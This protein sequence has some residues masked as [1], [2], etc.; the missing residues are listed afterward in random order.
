MYS[1][2]FRRLSMM[3]V[4]LFAIIT[5]TFFLMHAVPGGPFVSE[6]ML[7]PEIAAALNAKYGLDLPIWQQYFN[8]LGRILTFDLGPSFKYPGV[9]I[10]SMIAAGLPVTLRTGLLAVICV[11]ALGVPLG[12]VA[13]LNRNRWPDTTVM[14]IATLGVAIPSYVIA[15]VSLYVFALRLGWVPT[16]GLDDWRGY[17]LPVFALSGFWISFVSRLT[18]SSL[19][20]TLDQDFITTARAKGLRPDQILFKHG[21]RNSL[22]PVVTVLSPVVAN[23]I[24]GSFVIEQIFALPG[25]GRQFV[26]SI[27]NRDYTAIMGI[28]I[29]YAAILMV[30]ILIVDLLYVWLDPRIKLTKAPA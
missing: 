14:F 11:V 27:T 13:A 29:F 22:L 19:L 16:F 17:F 12:I 20:E 25:I 30:M 3:A 28:T 6:R 5:L 10:N 4:T 26:L 7:A 15:T 21:L 18:R 1:Y 2:F 23:L 24:T 9:S 8:Y